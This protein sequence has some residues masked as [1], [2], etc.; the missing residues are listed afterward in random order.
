MFLTSIKV[1]YLI[2]SLNTPKNLLD[3]KK[4]LAGKRYQVQLKMSSASWKHYEVYFY[5]PF[6]YFGE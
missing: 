2:L 1:S 5:K 6:N 3:T 4:T